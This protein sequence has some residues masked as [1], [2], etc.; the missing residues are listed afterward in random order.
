[1]KL[2]F[3]TTNYTKINDMKRVL[4]DTDIE[5][6]TPKDLDIYVDVEE[7][8][9]TA[10]ENAIKKAEAYYNIANMPTIAVDVSFYI[11]NLEDAKQPGLFVRRVGGKVLTD[12]EMQ[13]YYKDLVTSIGGKTTA[14][15]IKALAII[16]SNGTKSIEIKDDEFTLVDTP[17]KSLHP[18]YPIDSL[19]IDLKTNKYYS[20]MNS[21]EAKV[22][23]ERLDKKCA[24]FI[25]NSLK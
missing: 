1:M 8:G 23:N 9:N 3:A 11:N 20:D 14:Y 24:E 21:E 5:I 13:N 15:Y 10:T 25:T 19:S 7:D 2:L 18:G 17:T 16:T 22:L 4:E 12:E 6:I